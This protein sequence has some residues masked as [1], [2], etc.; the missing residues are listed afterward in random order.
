MISRRI[1]LLLALVAAGCFAWLHLQRRVRL[2]VRSPSPLPAPSAR[3]AF[4]LERGAPAAPSK[5]STRSTVEPLGPTTAEAV[6]RTAP[7]WRLRGRVVDRRTGEP[8]PHFTLALAQ[9]ERSVFELALVSDAWGEFTSAPSFAAGE[10]RIFPEDGSARENHAGF[11]TLA[12]GAEDERLEVLFEV[13]PTYR[14][15]LLAPAPLAALDFLAAVVGA[16]APPLAARDESALTPVRA[17]T[18]DSPFPWVRFAPQS[19][20][21]GGPPWRLELVSRSGLYHGSVEVPSI[22]GVHPGVLP[23]PIETYAALRVEAREPTQHT[24]PAAWVRLER[25]ASVP[26]MRFEHWFVPEG[27]RVLRALEPGLWRLEVESYEHEP[28]V[29]ELELR[30]GLETLHTARLV[31]EVGPGQVRGSVTSTSGRYV[32]SGEVALWSHGTSRSNRRSSLQWA[33][34]ADGRRR[35]HFHFEDIPDG[36]YELALL[37]PESPF[38]VRPAARELVTLPRAESAPALEFIVQDEALTLPLEFRG[39]DAATGLPVPLSAWWRAPG[40][41]SRWS[42][43]LAPGVF[44]APAWPVERALEWVVRGPAGGLVHGTLDDLEREPDRLVAHAAPGAGFGVQLFLTH[45]GQPVQGLTLAFDGEACGPSSSTGRIVLT[46]PERPR[47]V[48]VRTPGWRLPG[49]T[50]SGPAPHFELE[51]WWAQPF[52]LERAPE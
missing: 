25:V 8:V 20:D 48:E 32:V 28:Y 17:P 24:V 12:L 40:G 9:P 45:E 2:P 4:E 37:L 23:V 42:E 26:P 15:E 30:A 1:L 11:E 27:G 19:I 41:W 16:G 36:T 3:T 39:R 44:A 38:D 22:V 6:A 46:L 33:D 13:G 47:T 51:S 29:R 52:P 5:G 34:D 10:L 21:A 49:G 43:S 7:G 31:P 50:S 18:P 14:L 35:A